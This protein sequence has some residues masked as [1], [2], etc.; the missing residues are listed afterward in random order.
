M[1]NTDTESDTKRRQVSKRAYLDKAGEECDKIEQASGARYTL[2]GDG[3]KSFDMQFGEPGKFAVMCAIFGFH[4]KVGNVANTVLNDKDNPGTP[5][6][7][8]DAIEEFI[9]TAQSGTWAERTG[10]VGIVIDKDALAGAVIEVA[11]AAGKATDSDY[12]RI[13]QR[14]EEDKAY[15]KTVRQVPEVATEYAKRVGKATKTL[16]DIL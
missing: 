12:A 2:L 10:G 4:T 15:V 14:M 3:G 16:A 6:E 11:K 9:S 1:S 5:A 8:A 7:A 13:R